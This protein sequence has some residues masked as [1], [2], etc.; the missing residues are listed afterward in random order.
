VVEFPIPSEPGP[1]FLT[2]LRNRLAV[3]WWNLRHR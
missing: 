2:D 3:A 1:K